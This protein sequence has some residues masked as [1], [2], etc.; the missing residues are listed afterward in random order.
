MGE[1]EVGE[2]ELVSVY[3]PTRNRRDLLERAISSVLRQSHEN[4]ELIVSNDCSTDGT[5]DYLDDLAS[6]ERRLIPLHNEAPNGAP[7]AR[8]RA[9]HKSKGRFITGLDD[10]DEFRTDRIELFVSEWKAQEASGNSIA[11]LFSESVMTDGV[12]SKTTTDRKSRVVYRDLF[13]H[14]YIGNQVFC[15]REHLIDI[16]GFDER[17]RAWQDLE[18]FMRLV[19]RHGEARLVPEATYVCH[20]ERDRDRISTNPRLLR[21]AF[22][23][24]KNKHADVPDELHQLLFL[25]MFSPFYRVK[26]TLADWKQLV[27]WRAPPR[28]MARMLRATARNNLM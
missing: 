11:C 14:N 9:I 24:I 1:I 12:T 27:E 10:D 7:A 22:E 3:L 26:P 5:R 28:V 2:S 23:M 16:G 20:I 4:I 18:T 17:M 15:P 21:S 13:E 19:M 6:R 8:N 25:Q